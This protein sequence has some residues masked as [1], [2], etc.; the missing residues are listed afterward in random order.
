MICS[1]LYVSHNTGS[2]YSPADVVVV[3]V[4]GQAR[5]RFPPEAVVRV[6]VLVP[7]RVQHRH[8][9]EV[10]LLQHLVFRTWEVIVCLIRV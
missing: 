9:V 8:Y 6:R 2:Q 3:G 1:L 5:A 7:V 4:V 10:C